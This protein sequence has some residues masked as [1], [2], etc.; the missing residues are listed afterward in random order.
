MRLNLSEILTNPGGRIPFRYKLDLSD[1]EF[2]GYCPVAEPVQVSGE[3]RNSA[4]VLVL[5]AEA[6]TNL[7]CVCDRCLK[8]FSRPQHTQLD[9]ILA[10]EL[11]GEEEGDIILLES[12]TVDVSD[13]VTSAIIL[14]METKNLCSEDCQGLCPKCGKDLNEGPCDCRPEPDPRLAVLNQLLNK[15]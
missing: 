12:D 14:E 8:E 11:S 3:V 1:L 5:T 2:S 15:Q 7:H 6:D 4:G 13:L 10:S 9:L